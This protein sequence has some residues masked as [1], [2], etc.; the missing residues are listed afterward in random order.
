MT[1]HSFIP[2]P[3]CV[4]TFP[5]ITFSAQGLVARNN[6]YSRHVN[7]RGLGLLMA[8]HLKLPGLKPVLSESVCE[9]MG[10][11]NTAES[12]AT[13]IQGTSVF[14]PPLQGVLRQQA[15]NHTALN[16]TADTRTARKTRNEEGATE[17]ET[18][19]DDESSWTVGGKQCT[20]QWVRQKHE[21]RSTR[22][23]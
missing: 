6:L 20:A 21:F 3:P 22:P 11:T 13:H 18:E 2:S 15:S 12:S 5:V 16:D 9:A 19:R 1:L 14:L 23:W 17:T 8:E 7:S 10:H 4:S